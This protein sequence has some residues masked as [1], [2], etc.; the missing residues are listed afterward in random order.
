MN[1]A[2]IDDESWCWRR[3]S[4][5]SILQERQKQF[6]DGISQT[7]RSPPTGKNVSAGGLF[8]ELLVTLNYFDFS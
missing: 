3:L 6:A 2:A 7:A 8:I 1:V 4:L 5:I